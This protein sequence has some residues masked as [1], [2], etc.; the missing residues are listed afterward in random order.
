MAD[1]VAVEGVNRRTKLLVLD[2]LAALDI[3]LSDLIVQRE[4]VIDYSD[5]EQATGAQIDHSCNDLAH[6]E[7]MDAKDTQ[8][9]Q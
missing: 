2:T 7:P 9:R 8:E 5:A 3:N 6:V 1:N 4:V